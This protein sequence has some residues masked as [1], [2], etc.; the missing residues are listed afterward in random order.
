MTVFQT[1]CDDIGV[2]I[3]E[4]KS[5]GPFTCMTFWGLEKDTINMLNRI[6]NPKC[7]ELQ[8]LLRQ[9]I[10]KRKTTLKQ[11]LSVI[12]KLKFILQKLSELVEHCCGVYTIQ[13]WVFQN[14][15]IISGLTNQGS[16]LEWIFHILLCRKRR[17]NGDP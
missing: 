14:S 17:L 6:P 13:Q 16:G 12:G 4:E 9:L 7:A 8:D 2:P 11:L 15:A 10:M 5:E 1:I 3:A